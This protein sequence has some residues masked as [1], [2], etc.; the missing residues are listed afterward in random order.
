[1]RRSSGQGHHDD[2]VA[3]LSGVLTGTS[4][5]LGVIIS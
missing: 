4:S 5:D 2:K 1:M 3:L